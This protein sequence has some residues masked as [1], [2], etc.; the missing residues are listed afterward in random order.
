MIEY[1]AV[2]SLGGLAIA[3]LVIDCL[4]TLYIFRNRDRYYEKWN[5]LLKR[6]PKLTVTWFV[7]W[8]GIVMTLCYGAVSIFALIGNGLM[9]AVELAAIVNNVRIGIPFFGIAKP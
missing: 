5:L 2:I 9:V 1:Y 6:Y 4:Q 3:L 8:I 7:L